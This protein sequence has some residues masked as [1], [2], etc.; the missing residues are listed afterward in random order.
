MAFKKIEINRDN[1]ILR[2]KTIEA[3]KKLNIIKVKKT[4]HQ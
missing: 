3:D 1:E 4:H 2:L